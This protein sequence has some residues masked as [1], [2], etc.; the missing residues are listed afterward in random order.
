MQEK[1]DFPLGRLGGYVVNWVAVV[2]I[3]VT[4][5]VGWDRQ[6]LGPRLNGWVWLIGGLQFFVLPNTAAVDASTMSKSLSSPS[7][8]FQSTADNVLSTPRLRLSRRG[9]FHSFRLRPVAVQK[10]VISRSCESAPMLRRTKGNTIKPNH[11]LIC[12][13]VKQTADALS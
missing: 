11:T 4:S 2:F 7:N 5:A 9:D 13:H 12:M 8:L 1:P 3:V 10:K 6:I